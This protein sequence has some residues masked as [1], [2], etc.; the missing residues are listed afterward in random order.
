M[1]RPT[2]VLRLPARLPDTKLLTTHEVAELLQVDPSTVSKWVDALIL[3]G[4]RTPGGHRRVLVRDV[5]KMALDFGAYI[6]PELGG[7]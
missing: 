1:K 4:Y 5:R 7:A 6:P 2:N 3:P